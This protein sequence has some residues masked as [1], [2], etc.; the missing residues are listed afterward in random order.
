MIYFPILLG[1]SSGRKIPANVLQVGNGAEVQELDPH[2]VSGVTEHRVLTSLFEGLTDCD[3]ATLEPVPAVAD[4][5][6]VSEDKLLYTFHLRK[7]ARWSNGDRVTAQDFA[8]SWKRILSPALGSEY[9]YLLYCL[10]N[11]RLFNEGYLRDF[12]EVGVRVLDEFTLEAALE[13]PT[14]YFLSMHNHYAWFPVHQATIEKFGKIDERGTQWTRT[15]NLV[16][17]GPFILTD[18]RPNEI[19]SVRRNPHYWDGTAVRLD[20]IDYYPIDNQQTEERSFRAGMLHI[21]STIPLHRVEV[22]RREHPE[23]LNLHPYYGSYFYRLNITRPPFDNPLV[24][25]AFALAV[26]RNELTEH[27]L[28]GNEQAAPS[29]VPPD[30]GYKSDYQVMF[31]VV[32]A[33]K[34][35][36]E[37]G[38]PDGKGLPPVEILYNTSEAHRTIAEAIQRMWREYLNV[39][40][41]LLNQDW[42]VYLSSLNNLDYTIA[43]SSWIGDVADPMNFLECFQTGVGNNRTGWSSLRYD[44]FIESA[45][46]EADIEKR[47]ALLQQAEEI[48]LEEAPIIPIYFYTWKFLKAPEVKGLTPN[49]LGYMRWKD[50]YLVGE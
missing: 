33:Q 12:S 7:D 42:K 50:L 37:A 17:N 43:R 22:Y 19:I 39:D 14:P 26:D 16:G 38:Y 49:L 25:K 18:W 15:G 44:T 21:T 8:Y 31:D 36:A 9:A 34:L 23:A 41:R 20:G 11:A 2:V 10:K 48:L 3:A 1:C 5:W 46:A 27:V 4:S 29:L 28:T 47:I 40:V 45:Y 30:A 6:E 13:H 32:K 24:R 35:L